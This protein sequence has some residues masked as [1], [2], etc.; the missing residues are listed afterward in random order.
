VAKR[1][2][3]VYILVL[4]VFS[5][6]FAVSCSRTEPRIPFGYIELV[7]YQE[8]TGP[9]E[10]FSFFVISE[11]D[12]GIENLAELRLYHD[13]EGLRWILKSDDWIIYESEGRTWIGSR[14]ISMAG[15]DTLPRGQYRAVLV[16]KGGEKTE[17]LFTFDAPESSRFPFPLLNVSEGQYKAESR[18]PENK[19]ICYD[20]QGNFINI[21]PLP[22]LAGS[23]SELDIPSNARTVALWAE[24]PEHSTSALTDAVSIR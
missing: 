13:R 8:N 22:K 18:Y 20:E 4:A 10:R 19:F 17:R 2:I 6:A 12:D 16:N 14:S 24:D 23:V 11:D 5:A 15:D 1:F 21:L 7:Y 9:K 3:T